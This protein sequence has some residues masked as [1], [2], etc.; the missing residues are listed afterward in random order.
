[1]PRWPILTCLCPGIC[2]NCHSLEC[3]MGSGAHCLRQV[4]GE[5]SSTWGFTSSAVRAPV[6]LLRP[7][8]SR[9][10]RW[11]GRCEVGRLEKVSHTQAQT[12]RHLHTQSRTKNTQRDARTSTRETVIYSLLQ[13]RQKPCLQPTFLPGNGNVDRS[14]IPA[15]SN[16]PRFYLPTR[17]VL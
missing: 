11:G 3:R 15:E 12:H 6:C 17:L 13:L 7:L 8:R 16:K 1:M 4:G 2:P 10:H 9:G 14:T 5:T